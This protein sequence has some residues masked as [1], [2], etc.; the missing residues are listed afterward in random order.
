MSDDEDVIEGLP[1]WVLS[2]V[3]RKATTPEPQPAAR[4]VINKHDYTS[5]D[6][7]DKVECFVVR[8]LSSGIR[9]SFPYH[10]FL[11][12]ALHEPEGNFLSIVTTR[13][14]IELRGRNLLPVAVALEM[15]TC[16]CLTEYAPDVHAASTDHAAPFIQHIEVTTPEPQPLK[17][18]ER[19]TKR[20]EKPEGQEA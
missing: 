1:D 19:G 5:L 11:S 9:Y 6:T 4:L 15:K 17:K 3:E 8:C 16:H 2:S 18:P 10:T 13:A 7:R 20:E 14:V 12:A